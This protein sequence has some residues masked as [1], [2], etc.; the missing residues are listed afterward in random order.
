MQPRRL[1]PAP[2][3]RRHRRSVERPRSLGERQGQ[4]GRRRPIRRRVKPLLALAR[5][6][7]CSPPR[8][9]MRGRAAAAV[10]DRAPAALRAGRSQRRSG[11][12]A[13][14]D[15]ARPHGRRRPGGAA[16]RPPADGLGDRAGELGGAL[17]RRRDR[18]QRRPGPRPRQRAARAA[19]SPPSSSRRVWSGP[20]RTCSRCACRR[21]ISGC[22]CAGRSTSS[23]SGPTKRPSSARPRRLSPGP[24]HARRARR[25]LR[26]FR[27]RFACPSAAIAAPRLLAGIAGAGDAAARRR[28]QPRLHRLYLSLASRPGHR[29]SPCSPRATAV[30]IAAYAARRFAPGRAPARRRRDRGRRGRQPA[31]LPLVRSQGARR[32]PRRRRSRSRLA[33]AIG[34]RDRPALRQD[35]RWPPPLALVALMAWQRTAFLDQAYYLW[36]AVLLVALVAE[37]VASLRRARAER[38][39]RD[40]ARRGSGRAA[41]PSR[42]RGRADP[43]AQ[44]RQP[45]PSG[46]R[47]RHRLRSAPPTIIATSLLKDGR[48]PA[49]HDEPR[50]PPRHAAR[51]LRA[52]AQEPRGQ[53]RPRHRRSRRGPAAAALLTLSDGSTVPVGRCYRKRRSAGRLTLRPSPSG[54]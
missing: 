46:R 10:P 54:G 9:P 3:G 17:E 4:S 50:P 5:L 34:L 7:S 52:R 39:S 6:A 25:G 19:S 30:L 11:S 40:A 29:R 33:A 2:T 43:R 47:K 23:K 22:R 31:L 13:P 44:G 36:L 48:S 28:G 26:L 27:R 35:R 21:I 38:D 45:H 51:A 53:P 37:Q 1:A 14:G 8:A 20:A 12:H 32:D 49:G 16:A 41:R 18:P 15:I 42:A 24:A